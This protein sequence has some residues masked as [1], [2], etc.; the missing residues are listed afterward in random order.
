M[1]TKI[2]MIVPFRIIS[3][4]VR[5]SSF[6]PTVNNSHT[7]IDYKNKKYKFKLIVNDF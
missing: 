2:A 1:T 7:I 6:F 4:V 5:L 3:F